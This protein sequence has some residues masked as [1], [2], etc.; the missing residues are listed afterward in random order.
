[1]TT[2]ISETLPTTAAKRGRPR[3]VTTEIGKEF[4]DWP[5]DVWVSKVLADDMDT[6][7]TA[8]AL[9]NLAWRKDI[10]VSVLT[11]RDNKHM[12]HVKKTEKETTDGTQE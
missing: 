1:M 2:T 4:M 8:A 6:A 10:A 7:A 12:I 5:F 9:R 3:G 11:D